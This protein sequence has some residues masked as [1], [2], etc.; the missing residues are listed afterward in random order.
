ML[1]C[2]SCAG[3]R[4]VHRPGGH[5]IAYLTESSESG[6]YLT[7]NLI[8]TRLHYASLLQFWIHFIHSYPACLDSCIHMRHA[9]M[10]WLQFITF[11]IVSIPYEHVI[12]INIPSQKLIWLHGKFIKQTVYQVDPGCLVTVGGSLLHPKH[13][14]RESH[15]PWLLFGTGAC[16]A[17]LLAWATCTRAP[18]PGSTWGSSANELKALTWHWMVFIYKQRLSS[19]YLWYIS[20][21]ISIELYKRVL[22]R[23]R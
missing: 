19:F 13:I 21:S 6:K 4:K 3:R 8:N 12:N 22:F 5:T 7:T 10:I 14:R 15:P 17:P 2:S 23:D 18:L 11:R 16:T 20:Y 1:L 9:W